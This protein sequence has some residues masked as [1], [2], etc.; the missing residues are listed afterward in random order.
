V[1]LEPVMSVQVV[2]PEQYMGEVIGDLN[3]RRGKIQSMESR[4]G[5]QYING[6]VPLAQMFGYSTD[7]RSRTQG[8]AAYTMEFSQYAAVPGPIAAEIIKRTM[9]A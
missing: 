2:T 5:T 7:L 3:S 9:G 1:L 8:R 6:V 4:L